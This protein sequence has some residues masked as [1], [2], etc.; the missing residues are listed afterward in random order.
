M[1][2]LAEVAFPKCIVPV[3]YVTKLTAILK[4][5]NLSKASTTEPRKRKKKNQNPKKKKN[6]V[7]LIKYIREDMRPRIMAAL[8]QPPVAD[9]TAGRPL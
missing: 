5:V 9:R 7:F 8:V 4:V 2:V 6:R 1:T 3:K